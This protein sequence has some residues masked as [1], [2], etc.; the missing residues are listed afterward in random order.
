MNS[1]Y[2][3]QTFFVLHKASSRKSEK[4]STGPGKTRRRI[5]LSPSSPRKRVKSE[6][7][8]AEE[9]DELRYEHLRMEAFELVWSRIDSTIKVFLFVLYLLSLIFILEHYRRCGLHWFWLLRIEEFKFNAFNFASYL[10]LL[11]FIY[12]VLILYLSCSKERYKCKITDVAFISFS[13]WS[14]R[15]LTYFCRMFWGVSILMYW[16]RYIAG[17]A[18]PSMLLNHLEHLVLPKQILLFQLWLMLPV[19]G[20]SLG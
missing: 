11:E 2:F 9:W 14:Y 10:C 12:F 8:R 3:S 20:C 6:A 1:F 7:E 5:D 16:T 13:Q 4:R 18:S 19:N 17:F 15:I